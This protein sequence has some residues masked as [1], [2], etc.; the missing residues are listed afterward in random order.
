MKKN[1]FE[2]LSLKIRKGLMVSRA[3]TFLV[4][5]ILVVAFLTLNLWLNKID[6]PKFDITENQLFSLSEASQKEMS[7]VEQD[8]RIWV[9]GFATND[10]V[11]DLLKQYNKS[12]SK[13]TYEILTEEVNAD[14]VKKYN[15]ESGNKALVFEVGDTYKIVYDS[16]FVTYDYT[17]W[18]QVDLTENAITNAILNLTIAE[19]PKLYVLTG[20]DELSIDQYLTKILA[21]LQNEVFEYSTLNLL[22]AGTIPED[23]DLLAVFS[24]QKDLLDQETNVILDYINKGGNIIFTSDFVS[25]EES[26]MPN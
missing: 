16:D 24:P 8:V 21:Y 19:K 23:C 2:S 12:N 9:Y 17:T 4:V 22:T 14:K 15:L 1:F 11:V 13:I 25:E 5:S 10:S 3:K 18:Q 20:H 6:L 26:N 7:Y